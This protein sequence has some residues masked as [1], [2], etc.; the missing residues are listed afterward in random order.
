MNTLPF[1]IFELIIDHGNLNA[2]DVRRF[3]ST[4][5]LFYNDY[6]H[7]LKEKKY[8]HIA[9]NDDTLT[10]LPKYC[11]T[12][13]DVSGGVYHKQIRQMGFN[14][15]L[16]RTI[17]TH[18]LSLYKNIHTLSLCYIH[19]ITDLSPIKHVHT[20]I[21]ERL[22]DVHDVSVLG[23]GDVKSLTLIRM[24]GVCDLSN[25]KNMKTLHVRDCKNVHDVSMLGSVQTLILEWLH[26]VTDISMLGL[27]SQQ[28]SSMGF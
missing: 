20:L 23:D 4:C 6:Q 22:D 18:D 8:E 13:L 21:L 25:L 12:I 10:L 28:F 27:G 16:R 5:R 14:V 1:D 7:R 3:S 17:L 9:T 2:S 11:K 24:H 26:G 15:K 19:N